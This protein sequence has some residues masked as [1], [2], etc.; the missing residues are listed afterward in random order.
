MSDTVRIA[1]IAVVAI[2]VAKRV[3]PMVPGV[4]PQAAAL[5]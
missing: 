4:G 3:L 2:V 5:L 1:L